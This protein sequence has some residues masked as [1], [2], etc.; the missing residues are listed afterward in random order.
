ME[1]TSIKFRSIEEDYQRVTEAVSKL[2]ERA[3]DKDERVKTIIALH[4]DEKLSYSVIDAIV[5]SAAMAG[6]TEFQFL[7]E[8]NRN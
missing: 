4:A 1:K 8:A 5:V 2:F 6:I 7:A 3:R